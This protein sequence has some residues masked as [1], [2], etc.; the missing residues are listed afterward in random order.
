MIR[1]LDAKPHNIRFQTN[2]ATMYRNLGA[3]QAKA[4]ELDAARI[5]Y[6]RAIDLLLP[7]HKEA[8][9]NKTFRM[10]LA[11]VYNNLGMLQ[12]QTRQVKA[13]QD[14]FDRALEVYEPLPK[15]YPQD[16]SLASSIGG[17]YNNVGFLLAAT[18]E[19]DKAASEYFRAIGAQSAA[20][21][22][23][24]QIEKYREFLDRHYANYGQTLRKLNQP[25]AARKTALERGK[26]WQSDGR[27]LMAV[28]E[29]LALAWKLMDGRPELEHSANRCVTDVRDTLE[30]VAKDVDLS[31]ELADKP[32]FSGLIDRPEIAKLMHRA[33]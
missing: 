26:L 11:A 28:A 12:A 1:A 32:A 15:M 33:P 9:E 5:S 30:K 29:E 14:S 19:L 10:E 24:P 13:A 31:V 17:V 23:A 22:L 6:Q 4:Q 20:L 7:L 25:E 3:F 18:G 16:H 8:A 21:K 27:R 2:L